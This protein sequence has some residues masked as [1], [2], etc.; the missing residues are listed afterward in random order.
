M[1]I[2]K[3]CVYVAQILNISSSTILQYQVLKNII[4]KKFKLLLNNPR[5]DYYYNFLLDPKMCLEIN[6]KYYF[7][8]S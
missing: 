7:I 5:N 2:Y 3:L 8:N 4:L 1:F 6:N